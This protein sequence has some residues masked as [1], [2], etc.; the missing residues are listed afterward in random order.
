M[1]AQGY[2]CS[3][4]IEPTNRFLTFKGA[5]YADYST[6][7]NFYLL[8]DPTIE[9]DSSSAIVPNYFD[10]TTGLANSKLYQAA[11]AYGIDFLESFKIDYDFTQEEAET[12]TGPVVMP[13]ILF[14]DQEAEVV[15]LNGTIKMTSLKLSNEGTVYA[16]ARE[17]GK[18]VTDPEDEFSTIEVQTRNPRTP[19]NKQIN[20]CLD[21]NNEAAD[22]CSK[23]IITDASQT[24]VTLQ[25]TNLK[26]N[27][28]YIVYY[29]AAN[30]YPIK[31]IFS[32][33]IQSFT[34]AVLSAGKLMSSIMALIFLFL[35]L[36]I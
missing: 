4:Y 22:A 21:W 30:E 36:L 20:G 27:T 6:G 18:V 3:S 16:I 11:E 32:N 28:V 7:F 15:E 24:D 33:V 34:I 1:D 35:C 26:S 19:S 2:S 9:N 5:S 14:F 13:S 12:S 10:T 31:P 23:A 17:I 8:P 29:T 25:L